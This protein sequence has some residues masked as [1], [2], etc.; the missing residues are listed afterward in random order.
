M[1]AHADRGTADDRNQQ[2]GRFSGQTGAWSP[3]R[4][5]APAGSAGRTNDAKG[6]RAL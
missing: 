4:R 2:D 5:F 1:P 6:G 3:G